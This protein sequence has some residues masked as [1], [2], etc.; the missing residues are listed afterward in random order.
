MCGIAGFNWPNQNLL[1][2]M[3]DTLKHRGPDDE[4]FYVDSS[5]SLGH[6]RLSVIDTS[7]K[8]HQPMKFRN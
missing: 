3:T 1:E 6:R 4:G 2:E 5:V 7:E 8:G